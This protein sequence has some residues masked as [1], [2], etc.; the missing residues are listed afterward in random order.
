ML[1]LPQ[2]RLAFAQQFVDTLALGRFSTQRG[3]CFFERCDVGYLDQK[4]QNLA[5]HQIRHVVDKAEPLHAICTGN[6]HLNGP[7]FSAQGGANVRL[8]ECKPDRPKQIRHRGTH[9]T[10]RVNPEPPP[11][12][13]VGELATQIAVPVAEH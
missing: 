8:V 1:C 11:V 13:S 5:V 4:S 3:L 12:G 7:L 2:R 6:L 10:L 9:Q